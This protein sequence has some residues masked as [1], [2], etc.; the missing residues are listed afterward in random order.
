M[1]TTKTLDKSIY[2]IAYYGTYA[3]GKLLAGERRGYPCIASVPTW[4]T[5]S[6]T[7]CP[8]P[9]WYPAL[10]PPT[11]AAAQ[12]T[13]ISGIKDGIGACRVAWNEDG[14]LAFAG[15]GA[16]AENTSST[17]YTN[18]YGPPLLRDEAAFAV[19]RN[20]GETWNEVGLINTT[21]DWFNDVAP[22]I[23]C[24][25]I[26]L[27]SVNHNTGLAGMCNEFDSVW[28]TTLNPKVMA[29]LPL[30]PTIGYYWER[31]LTH[32]TSDSCRAA[33]SDRPLLRL[34]MGC[35]DSPYGE[36]VGWAAQLTNTEMWSPDY[37]D[38]WA[39]ISERD[40]IQDFAFESHTIIY[41]LSPGG[42]VHKLTYS[43][44]EWSTKTKSYD[45]LV[46]SAHTIAVIPSGKVLVGA[47][48]DGQD[49]ASYSATGGEQWLEIP[50]NSSILGNVHVA[51][52]SRLCQ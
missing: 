21:I 18:L 7:T 31:V 40:T 27:A 19:S 30:G 36:V 9:C 23:D 14:S 8:I 24:S 28:R 29:P 5:D 42:M 33:Q 34:P 17:W 47:A 39:S 48:S 22:S 16:L 13:C 38:F 2:S 15:T 52:D 35:D 44:T 12:G 37:G 49:A 41:N 50:K 45:S 46:G 11:G 10:K 51:F 26:Y 1:D 6:P 25:T 4:F 3:Q 43:G 32:T 20:N